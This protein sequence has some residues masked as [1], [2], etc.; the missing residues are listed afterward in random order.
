MV[1]VVRRSL[2]WLLPQVDRFN[3]AVVR[4]LE[5]QAEAV[6]QLAAAHRQLDEALGRVLEEFALR[7]DA[8]QKKLA[9]LAPDT[10]RAPVQYATPIAM[11]VLVAACVSAVRGAETATPDTPLL[12]L[13]S[14]PGDWL[15]LLR[16][17]GCTAGGWSPKRAWP[18][19]ARLGVYR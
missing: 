1:R 10:G 13:F 2:F 5:A 12:D 7:Q 11:P 18:P 6:G 19:A 17:E 14:G 16:A 4:M 3:T 9:T 8:I 15:E